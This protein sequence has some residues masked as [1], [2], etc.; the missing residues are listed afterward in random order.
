M[1]WS[2][3]RKQKWLGLL[4]GSNRGEKVKVKKLRETEERKEKRRRRSKKVLRLEATVAK[5][6]LNVLSCFFIAVLCFIVLCCAVLVALRCCA[7]TSIA[8]YA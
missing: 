1:K 5:L 8:V 2:R 6:Q 7:V 4:T 3:G